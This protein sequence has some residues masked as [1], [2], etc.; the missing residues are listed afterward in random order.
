MY[1]LY[2]LCCRRSI[3]DEPSVA[4]S[5]SDVSVDPIDVDE[6][7]G[8]KGN[9][10]LVVVREFGLPCTN[11]LCSKICILS[12]CFFLKKWYKMEKSEL[13]TSMHLLLPATLIPPFFNSCFLYTACNK[14]G[15][16]L[17][18]KIMLWKFL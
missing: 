9:F 18:I 1:V 2:S 8:G 7:R 16:S 17:G 4:L 14:A 5:P 11:H 10:A 15:Q 6:V 3:L 12:G 13:L